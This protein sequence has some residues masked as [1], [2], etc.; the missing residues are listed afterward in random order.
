MPG[1]RVSIRELGSLSTVGGIGGRKIDDSIPWDFGRTTGF[2][3]PVMDEFDESNDDLSTSSFSETSSDEEEII[4]DVRTPPLRGNRLLNMVLLRD[5]VEEHA[6]CKRCMEDDLKEFVRYCCNHGFD[7][8]SLYES[9]VLNRCNSSPVLTVKEVTHG[10]GTRVI[11]C[12]NRCSI[13]G[14]NDRRGWK[15]HCVILESETNGMKNKTKS[16]LCKYDINVKFC[17]AMQLLGLGGEH[18]SVLAAFLDLP[19]PHKWRHQFSV[20]EKFLCPIME[21]IKV[22]CQELAAETEVSLTM[23]STE[24][25]IEQTL[26]HNDDPIHG[27][28]SALVVNMDR[29]PDM[30]FL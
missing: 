23:A 24:N 28:A 1:K 25:A 26:M 20:L 5:G 30:P 8:S 19:E 22:Q 18:A 4:N 17:L 3:T 7:V 13:F 6:G 10:L 16:E 9:W 29:G 11:L 21:G 2:V 27:L 14:E 15:D 12:C